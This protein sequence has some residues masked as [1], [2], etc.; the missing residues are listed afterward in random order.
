MAL[1]LV[2]PM[3]RFSVNIRVAST[4]HSVCL[5]QIFVIYVCYRGCTAANSHLPYRGEELSEENLEELL[6]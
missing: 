5:L 3:R 4:L 2:I 6:E 1:A